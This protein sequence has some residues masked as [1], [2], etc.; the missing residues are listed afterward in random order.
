MNT[1]FY[2]SASTFI[3][4]LYPRKEFISLHEP[5]FTSIDKKYINEAIDS[6]FVSSAGEFINTFESEIS[7]YTNS[8][9]AVAV[10]NGTAALHLAL[11]MAGVVKSDIVITQSLTFVATVNAIKYQDATPLFIDVSKERMSLCPEQLNS[12]LEANAFID[13]KEVCRIKSSK[14]AIKALIVVHTFG[15]PADIIKI[16]DLCK[17]WHIVL[18]EDAAESLGS[19][20]KGQHTGTFGDY[21]ALSFNGNKIITTGG[22]GMLLCKDAINGDRAKHLSTTAKTRALDFY[23]DAIGYNYRMPNINAALGCAQIGYMNNYL[24]SKREIATLYE[25]FFE[26]SS[27]D[28]FKEPKNSSSNFWLNT[29]LAPNKEERDSFIKYTND[30]GIMTR[31]SWYLMHKLPIFKENI[32]SSLKNT[33][34]L[35]DR[36]INLPSSPITEKV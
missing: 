25:D 29:I 28:F 19:F 18:I 23:H 30:L 1:T 36:I 10:V 20:F 17:A 11:V 8:S 22:G 21:G 27:Y 31:P 26:N 14:K 6:T 13:D 33:E 7:G 3:K 32:S 9:S 4:N 24:K 34:W 15:H 35:S 12:F 16:S 5:S 2:K